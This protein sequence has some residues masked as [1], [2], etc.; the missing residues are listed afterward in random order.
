MLLTCHGH[1]EENGSAC[2]SGGFGGE[3]VC[4]GDLD[5]MSYTDNRSSILR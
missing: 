1:K 4:T 5:P 2:V 3:F